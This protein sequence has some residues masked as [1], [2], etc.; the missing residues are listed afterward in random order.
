MNST[1]I[2]VIIDSFLPGNALFCKG[3][4]ELIKCMF[5]LASWQ[6]KAR[7]S[8]LLRAV[9]SKIS[10]KKEIPTTKGYNS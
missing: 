2:I 5:L 8:K 9:S 3:F 4:R 6:N 7:W 10:S 1:F